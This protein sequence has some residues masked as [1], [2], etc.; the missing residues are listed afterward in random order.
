M[1]KSVA[2][3]GVPSAD[4]TTGWTEELVKSAGV[5]KTGPSGELTTTP[6]GFSFNFKPDKLENI[7]EKNIYLAFFPHKV[8]FSTGK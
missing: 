7:Y 5:K 8:F 2:N 6:A 3:P 4:V 1:V